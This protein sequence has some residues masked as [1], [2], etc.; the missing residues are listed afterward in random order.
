MPSRPR[1][2]GPGAWRLGA[3]RHPPTAVVVLAGGRVAGQLVPKRTAPAKAHVLASRAVLPVLVCHHWTDPAPTGAHRVVPEYT[4][5]P[6]GALY[7]THADYCGLHFIGRRK[8]TGCARV[9]SDAADPR[10]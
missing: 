4:C 1:C 2:P 7:P 10:P 6:R 9:A 3:G 5:G 8:R